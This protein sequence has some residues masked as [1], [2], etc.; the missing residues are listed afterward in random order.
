MCG[1]DPLYPRSFVTLSLP[2]LDPLHDSFVAVSPLPEL[3]VEQHQT[4]IGPSAVCLPPLSGDFY[5]PFLADY[6]AHYRAL[7]FSQFYPY[8]L[9]PGPETL[10]VLKE[11]MRTEEGI[12]PVRWGTPKGWLYSTTVAHDTERTFAVPPS[13]WDLPGMTPLPEH[14]E[15]EMG[16]P[17]GGAR[18]VRL[19]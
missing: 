16:V 3:D 7:G 15:F 18:D 4:G 10:K 13:Q 12:V 14:I 19:W 17:K 1:T 5:A 6:F 9:D 11:L 8:L 2:R